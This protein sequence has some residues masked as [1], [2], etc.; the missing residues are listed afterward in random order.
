M[1]RLLFWPLVLFAGFVANFVVLFDLIDRKP[2]VHMIFGVNVLAE[3]TYY[4]LFFGVATFVVLF[5]VYIVKRLRRKR[6]KRALP[7]RLPII[8]DDATAPFWICV[9]VAVAVLGVTTW[10]RWKP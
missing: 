9:A 5:P 3:A 6:V 1:N 7:N 8:Q 4:G 10:W 2:R